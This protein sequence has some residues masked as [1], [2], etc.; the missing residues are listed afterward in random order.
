MKEESTQTLI[1]PKFNEK[2][3]FTHYAEAI[4]NL[5]LTGDDYLKVTNMLP[6]LTSLYVPTLYFITNK[7]PI[8][9]VSFYDIRAKGRNKLKGFLL[10]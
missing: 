6:G 4:V 10:A 5:P 3:K 2:L 1:I 7:K 9:L 8:P